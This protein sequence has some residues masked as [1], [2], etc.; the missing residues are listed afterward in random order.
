M[1]LRLGQLPVR[2]GAL[3]RCLLLLCP[4][5]P[6]SCT[7]TDH[8]H[9][10][11][12]SITINHHQSPPQAEPPASDPAAITLRVRLPCGTSHTRRFLASQT[13]A[14]CLAWVSCVSGAS[15]TGAWGLAAPPF[16]GI[17]DPDLL[18]DP[19]ATVGAVAGGARQ[20][21]LFAVAKPLAGG[22]V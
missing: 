5:V 3:I 11:S 21:A 10:Q 9:H 12:P 14:D 2:K 4:P 15:Q 18:Q 19:E 20:V 7:R 8:A 16:S 13:L 6:R 17:S 22:V 1:E